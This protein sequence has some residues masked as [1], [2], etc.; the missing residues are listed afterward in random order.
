MPI[1]ISL[2]PEHICECGKFDR[3]GGTVLMAN[4][5]KALDA[6]FRGKNGIFRGTRRYFPQRSNGIGLYC[7]IY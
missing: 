3:G 6:N 1:S 7:E 4:V 5:I 2:L